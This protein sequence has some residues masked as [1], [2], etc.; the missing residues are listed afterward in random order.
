MLQE[1]TQLNE[2]GVSNTFANL[3]TFNSPRT[4]A[5]TPP[6]PKAPKKEKKVKSAK[7]TKV[8]SNAK[9]YPK[10][11]SVAEVTSGVSMG[12]AK[13]VR[14]RC[15]RT[16]TVIRTK[17][18]LDSLYYNYTDKNFNPITVANEIGGRIKYYSVSPVLT[19]LRKMDYVD[20]P[21]GKTY[22]FKKPLPVVDTTRVTATQTSPIVVSTPVSLTDSLKQYINDKVEER[23]DS[24]IE[25]KQSKSLWDKLS[26]GVQ[27]FK[28]AMR[29]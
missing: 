28:E 20:R 3:A 29:G 22:C 12:F 2:V 19:V 9:I 1:Q 26:R 16:L 17:E 18:I 6:E 25:T 10:E 23:V 14:D 27:A 4:T 24:V 21:N 11:K 15:S 13:A 7:K 8:K 5:M